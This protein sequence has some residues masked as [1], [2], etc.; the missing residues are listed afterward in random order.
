MTGR[1]TEWII[2]PLIVIILFLT[3]IQ[4]YCTYQEKKDHQQKSLE[5]VGKPPV[6]RE[7]ALHLTASPQ[8]SFIVGRI[9]HR[10]EQ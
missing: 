10:N 7:N 9:G 6:H 1:N 8:M 2:I 4:S 3:A 5:A